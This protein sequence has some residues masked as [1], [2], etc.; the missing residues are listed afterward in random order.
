[1]AKF[2]AV[3]GAVK[4]NLLEYERTYQAV[5]SNIHYCLEIENPSLSM[6]ISAMQC[7]R[8][9]GPAWTSLKHASDNLSTILQNQR[10]V[11][12]NKWALGTAAATA[13]SMAA[14]FGGPPGWAAGAVYAGTGAVAWSGPQVA[15]KYLESRTQMEGLRQNQTD[16]ERMHHELFFMVA[17]R[18]IVHGW[19]LKSMSSAAQADLLRQMGVHKDYFSRPELER[20]MMRSIIH[21]CEVIHRQVVKGIEGIFLDLDR[22]REEAV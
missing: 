4:S 12:R 5:V 14:F 22:P 21:E 7:V 6:Y 13:L 10:A 16:V 17:K 19:N 15:V 18:V 2:V 8:E 1:M 9:L 11:T 20:A 3:L